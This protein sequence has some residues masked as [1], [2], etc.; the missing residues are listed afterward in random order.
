MGGLLSSCEE[1]GLDCLSSDSSSTHGARSRPFRTYRYG[2]RR[3]A[4]GERQF[5]RL[6]MPWVTGAACPVVVLIHGGFW[7]Q[8]ATVESA[9]LGAVALELQRAGFGVVELEYRPVDDDGGGWPGSCTDVLLAINALPRLKEASFSRTRSW[10]D[11]ERVILLGVDAGGQLALYAAHH[12]AIA[13]ERAVREG[14]KPPIV[15][16]LTVGVAPCADLV[17]CYERNLGSERNRDSSSKSGG[18]KGGDAVERFMKCTPIGSGY[19]SYARASPKLL[20]PVRVPTLLVSGTEDSVV[21]HALTAQFFDDCQRAQRQHDSAPRPRPRL[22]PEAEAE[23]EAEA[24]EEEEEDALSAPVWMLALDGAD[25]NQPMR[26]GS[27]NRRSSSD[28]DG[29]RWAEVQ[30]VIALFADCDWRADAE[31]AARDR[32]QVF[33]AVTR[34]TSSAAKAA[35]AAVAAAGRGGGATAAAAAVRSP[36]GALSA[37]ER[38]RRALEK[39]FGMSVAAAGD[40]SESERAH[41]VATL[42]KAHAVDRRVSSAVR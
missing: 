41:I 30:E 19:E 4:G 12:L 22:R 21:P 1:S 40:I 42:A 23:A 13:A 2:D 6:H 39:R 20:L 5:M 38:E 7:R 14:K 27:L 8:D 32:I 24:E 29:G 35:A 26:V 25:H 9:G 28:R 15:P 10:I 34:L 33:G 18:G 11:L 3:F 17:Q 37:T 36:S 31:D 16:I